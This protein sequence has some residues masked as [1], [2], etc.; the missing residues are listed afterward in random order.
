MSA[1]LQ[2]VAIPGYADACRKEAR[3]R[4][5]AFLDGLEIV[6]GVE[7]YPLSLR[8]LIWLDMA[9]NGFVVSCIFDNEREMLA[10]AVQI[11]YFCSPDFTLPLSPKTNFILSFMDGIKEQQFIRKVMKGR[12]VSDV[13]NEVKSWQED[14]FMD[15]PTGGGGITGAAYAS[16]PVFIVDAFGD[17][18][19]PFTYDQI[20]DMPLRRIWQHLR[21]SMRRISGL[22]LSNPSDDIAVTYLQGVKI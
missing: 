10:H 17:A 22:T 18:G 15:A 6:C 20:M 1:T 7:V 5:T 11:L 13:I 21:I 12:I 16:Y 8:R 2:T 3:V 4:D 14:N 19:L 9:K